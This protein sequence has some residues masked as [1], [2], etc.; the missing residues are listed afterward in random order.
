M[1][2][3]LTG[4]CLITPRTLRS[5]FGDYSFVQLGIQER[6]SWTHSVSTAHYSAS[7]LPH[8]Y[9]L[10][11]LNAWLLYYLVFQ[12]LPDVWL[13]LFWKFWLL[14][15][16]W[17]LYLVSACHKHGS[18]WKLNLHWNHSLRCRWPF[19]FD[20]CRSSPNSRYGCI[21]SWQDLSG[22]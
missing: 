5:V 10:S 19:F 18:R 12:I 20:F 1:A 7:W 17:P 2:Y 4:F 14:L 15:G 16:R 11:I 22:I 13:R 21:A 3:A 6:F 9:C 8:V